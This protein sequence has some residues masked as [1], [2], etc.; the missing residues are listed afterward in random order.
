MIQRTCL[1]VG[2]CAIVLLLTSTSARGQGPG[3]PSAEARLRELEIRSG[4]RLGVVALDT[5]TWARI[6]HRGTERFALCSTFK[7]LLAA[8]VL[9][10]VDAGDETLGRRVPYTKADLL[11]YSPVTKAHVKEG[12]LTVGQLCEAAVEESDNAAANLLLKT[13]GGP[14]GLTKYLRSLGDE[15]TRLDRDEPALNS[16]LPDDPRDTTTPA[17]MV[18]TVRL[19]LLGDALSAASREKLAGWMLACKTGRARLSAGVPS[20]WRVGDKT[21]TGGRGAANDVAIIWPPGR[22]PILV[23]AYYSD[24]A[25][26]YEELNAVLAEVGEIVAQAFAAPAAK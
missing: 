3:G 15:V 18:E 13:V 12:A 16:N 25:R 10:R 21:G 14:E 26:G 6:G 23:A 11:D 17:S 7:L 24:S 1:L 4:G 22:K 9:S 2:T 5:A 20:D 19:L 8:S